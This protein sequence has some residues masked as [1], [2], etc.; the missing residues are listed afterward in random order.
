MSWINSRQFTISNRNGRH[1]VFHRN[2]AGNTEINVPA[3]IVSKGQAIA[4]LK[5][6]PTKVANPTRFKPRGA[7]KSA[8]PKKN[9]TRPF[10]RMVNGKKMVAF[11]N[12]AGKTYYRPAPPSPPK[13]KVAPQKYV[14]PPP[15]K[16]PPGGWR[17]PAPKLAPWVKRQFIPT[18]NE[19]AMTCDQLK[20]S[21]DSLTPIGKGR[22]GIVFTAT[23]PDG[24]KRHFAVKVAPR[25]LSA[26]RRGE[27]QPVDIEFNIQDAVQI[28][29]PNVVRIYKTMRCLDFIAPS[30]MD[31][32][33]VQN[34]ARYDKSQQG[35]ILMELATGGSL[36]SWL[37]KQTKV[38]DAIMAHIIKDILTALF[39]IHYRQPDF[40]HN[41][42]HMQNVFVADRGFIIGDF[43]WARLKKS[44]TNPAVNTANGTK[45]ASFWG[46][47][48]KTDERYDHHLFLN[49]L[50]TWATK[51]APDD[52]PKAIEFLKM[53]VPPGYRGS[54]D[55]HVSEWR[56]KYEDP[57]P[58]LPSL[59][60][61]LSNP[62][63]SGKK[64]VTSLNLGMAKAKLKPLKVKR[65]FSANL[66][67]AKA[68]LKPVG[69]RKPARLI[70]SLRLRRAK[71]ALKVVARPKPKPRITG[72]NLRAAKA[73]L[74]KVTNNS[75][76]AS[77]AKNTKPKVNA[78]ARRATAAVGGGMA[79]KNNKHKPFPREILRSAKF[80]K[81]ITKIYES[82]GGLNGGTNF[83][84]AWSKARKLAI[85]LVQERI[86]NNKAPFTPSPPKPKANLPPPLSPLGPPPKPKVNLP[87]PLSPLGP[88]P[89]P[90]PKPKAPSP[91]KRPNHKLSPTSGRAKV[92][93]KNSGRWVYANLYYSMEEL[94]AL[95]ARLNVS[96]KGLRSKANIAK[97]LF[98]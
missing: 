89:K 69:E 72:Y 23:Q 54:K 41:D 46:V 31:M 18:K 19:W 40:R 79:K 17:Y 55:T 11:I 7:P 71:A 24:N 6:N 37:K 76:N 90:R 68:K 32:P 63:L 95:A 44:G 74:R 15:P 8:A 22:Q 12:K 28:Y 91:P 9:G 58:G 59:A 92:K 34:S 48:P 83:D 43:G 94:K 67:N 75:K 30:R 27:P 62:F 26:K 33:N 36:D 47:G 25:D 45:T 81:M 97:K 96:T 35:I 38:T 85:N 21:L 88:P 49:E 52:H 80:N 3:Q 20:A 56:L 14:P 84:N 13:K 93:S 60:Q 5:A 1:Y 42:L 29:T 61:V 65:V 87:P 77:G 86:N 66:V 4:W 53:A 51:H 73:R 78:T 64:R 70:T 39:K 50:L 82:R 10:E 57:C 2:N 16:P 98:G